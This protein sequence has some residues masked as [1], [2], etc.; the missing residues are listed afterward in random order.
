MAIPYNCYCLDKNG[1]VT[2]DL[3]KGDLYISVSTVLK[4]EGKDLVGWALRTFGPEDNPLKAYQAYMD[5][6]SDLGSRIHAYVENDMKGTPIPDKDIQEDMLP[7]IESW[8]D[9]KAA[10]KIEMVASEKIVYSPKWRVAGT[11]DLVVRLND[12]LYVADFK[13]GG[14]YASAFTQMAAYKAFM[15][16]E[17]KKKRIEGIENADLLVL[18]LHRDGGSLDLHTLDSFNKGRVTIEDELGVF[19][20]LRYIWYQRNC[21][22]KKFE[23][24]IK[25][26]RDVLNPLEERFKEAFKL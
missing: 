6:V 18:N 21:K 3:N 2:N 5:K 15:C 20:A 7:A 23:A 13:T 16:Q 8:E 10:N 22:V 12:K 26:M 25:N 17:P 19:H 9:F 1:V 24:V 14:V 4:Q 11:V